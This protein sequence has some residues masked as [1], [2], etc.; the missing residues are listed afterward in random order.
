MLFDLIVQSRAKSN[1]KNNVSSVDF[2]VSDIT[3]PDFDYAPGDNV[4][5]D[6]DSN[7]TTITVLKD[8][9][10]PTGGAPIHV[11]DIDGSSEPATRRNRWD[12]T[13][14]IL[15]EDENHTPVAG[16]TVDGSFST[17][18]GGSCTTGSDGRCTITKTNIKSQN[19]TTTFSVDSLTSD[20]YNYEPG[21]NH[22]E[23]DADSSDGTSITIDSP[24]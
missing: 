17:G 7:G 4:D 19:T 23:Q 16:V 13:A 18:G 20:G 15:V 5:A 21:D 11:G 24:L 12:A 1:L 3:H 9:P 6:G 14:D 2:S 10:P 8:P 22:D